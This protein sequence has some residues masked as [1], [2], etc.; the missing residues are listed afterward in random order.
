LRYFAARADRKI[1]RDTGVN[2]MTKD[3]RDTL[4][5]LKSELDFIEKGGYGRSVR[6]PWLET[7]IFQDSPSCA[8]FPIREHDSECAL[9]EF[10]PPE[11]RAETTPCHFIPLNQTG[12]TVESSGDQQGLEEAIKN[13]LR[14]RILQIEQER[15]SKAC[16]HIQ[17]QKDM[18]IGSPDQLYVE[19]RY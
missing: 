9:M 16:N 3:D 19:K 1:L 12:E 4:E 13:W 6:T 7:S 2:V 17:V 5:L 8:C 14:V 10:V 18:D 15:A 11:R